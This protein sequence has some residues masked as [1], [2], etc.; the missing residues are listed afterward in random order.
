MWF[1]QRLIWKDV[2]YKWKQALFVF[3]KMKM[4]WPAFG[5]NSRLV[6]LKH[7]DSFGKEKL[8]KLNLFYVW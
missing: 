5:F 8:K 6:R 3:L 1:N 4:A 2:Y 7:R